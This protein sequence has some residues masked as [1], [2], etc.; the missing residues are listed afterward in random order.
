MPSAPYQAPPASPPA[1][2][3]PVDPRR[4][5]ILRKPL[6]PAMPTGTQ[7]GFPRFR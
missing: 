4:Q 3:S 5:A 2:P 7:A 1:S 6:D